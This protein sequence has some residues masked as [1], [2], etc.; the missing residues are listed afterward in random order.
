MQPVLES[1]RQFFAVAPSSRLGSWLSCLRKRSAPPAGLQIHGRRHGRAIL[2]AVDNSALLLIAGQLVRW[3]I[4][5]LVSLFRALGVDACT[6]SP[7]R[8]R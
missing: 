4:R 5:A 6:S 2:V 1:E 8:S 7:A 3:A